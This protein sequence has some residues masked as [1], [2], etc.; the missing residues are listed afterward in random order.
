VRSLV[1]PN[2]A[3]TPS[4]QDIKLKMST[5]VKGLPQF[6]HPKPIVQQKR[7][8]PT[9]PP[10]YRPQPVPKV[11]QTKKAPGAPDPRGPNAVMRSHAAPHTRAN[12]APRIE[13][14]NVLVQ[15]GACKPPVC[16]PKADPRPHVRPATPAP[17]HVRPQLRVAQARLARPNANR[18]KGVVQP[19][20]PVKYREWKA[21]HPQ[22]GLAD[23]LALVQN[24]RRY[25]T[26]FAEDD[27]PKRYAT[28]LAAEAAH[29][30]AELARYH[31]KPKKQVVKALDAL[32][33]RINLVLNE[34]HGKGYVNDFTKPALMG[35][36]ARLP[37]NDWEAGRHE[38]V[39]RTFSQL[40][41]KRSGTLTAS[42]HGNPDVPVVP[43]SEAKR[44][45]PWALCSLIK[46]IYDGWVSGAPLDTRT[47]PERGDRNAAVAVPPSLAVAR[48]GAMRSWHMDA[49]GL[50]PASPAA[51]APAA[52]V[53]A[54]SNYVDRHSA[55]P[56]NMGHAVAASGYIE[57]TGAGHGVDVANVRILLDYRQGKIFLCYHYQLW[58]NAGDN[59]LTHGQNPAGN[60]D[61]N[62]PWVNINMTA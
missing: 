7:A 59:P 23:Y 54:V 49:H 22:Q 1:F 10:V 52:N 37:T 46:R 33:D 13:R 17:S 14:P 4:L 58:S 62:N 15:R 28:N 47:V 48:S 8:T 5:K 3:L 38:G 30:D 29:F 11:L 12:N 16:Q 27:G 43:Y 44:Y 21:A 32:V 40:V 39:I 20:I 25:A 26:D 51:A 55:T 61:R 9:P 57:Y 6:V 35:G 36:A 56:N 18:H 31:N 60:L 34:A 2:S 50:L 42:T 19:Y 53:T 24:E 45:L 41:A